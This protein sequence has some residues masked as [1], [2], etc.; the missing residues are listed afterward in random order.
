MNKSDFPIFTTYPDLVY[1]DSASTSQ[2]PQKVIDAITQFY[3]H[4]NANIHRGL[5]G[6]S[7]DAT[8][9]YETTRVKVAKFINASSPIEIIFTSGTTM[10]MNMI[11]YGVRNQVQKDDAIIITEAEH[12]SNLLPWMRLAKEKKAQLLY[13]EVGDEGELTGRLKNTK[14]KIV[15]ENITEVNNIKILSVCFVSNVLGTINPVREIIHSVKLVNPQVITIIDGAQAI[16]HLPIDVEELDCDFFVFSGH[17]LFGPSGVGVVYG[18]QE[19]LEKFEPFLVGSQ[20][21]ADVSKDAFNIAPLPARFE[22]GTASLEAV[23]GLGAAID[24]IQERDLE[25]IRDYEKEIT[26]YALSKLSK[27]KGVSILGTTNLKKKI[28]L[29][30]FT[31][32]GIH[33]HDVSQIV[34]EKNICVR[35]GHHCTLPL[36][37]RFSIPA[38]TRISLAL[39]NTKEDIDKLITGIGEVKRIFGDA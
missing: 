38:S 24:Y 27:V 29:I 20:M 8:T 35:A 36:H 12:H 26:K 14:D 33:P 30:S 2:K 11:A 10:G 6:L 22:S 25:I 15:F 9:L 17:K 16:P 23:V 28:G 13:M 37:K 31:M 3:T 4:S 7:E 34:A 39:Y 5:Y 1:L 21:I 19:K 32:K 18:K